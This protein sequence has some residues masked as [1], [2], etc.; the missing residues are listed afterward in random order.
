MDWKKE[1]TDKLKDYDAKKKALECIP[2]ERERIRCVMES[3]R[4][5]DTDG[6]PV[7]GSTTRRE[8]R[9]LGCIVKLEELE[10]V[11]MQTKAW[12]ELVNLGL[13]VLDPEERLVLDRMVICPL[14]GNLDRLCDELGM[15]R[16]TVYRRRDNALRK[17][18]LALYGGMES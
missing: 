7:K 18:T 13:G 5:A 8:D 15:E 12:V 4:S 16:A 10:R 6:A 14:Q 17:F 9:L 1:A 11:E 2:L 3:I